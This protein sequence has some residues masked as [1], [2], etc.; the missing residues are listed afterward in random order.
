[1]ALKILEAFVSRD[2]YASFGP[3]QFHPK[4]FALA[5]SGHQTAY[6]ASYCS[7][8]WPTPAALGLPQ[9]PLCNWCQWTLW[10]LLQHSWQELLFGDM[11][12]RGSLH[13]LKVAIALHRS[14]GDMHAHSILKTAQG[15]TSRTGTV[16][17]D[18]MRLA[19]TAFSGQG[20]RV[21]HSPHI[22]QLPKPGQQHCGALLAGD[23]AA[24]WSHGIRALTSCKLRHSMGQEQK[25]LPQLPKSFRQVRHLDLTNISNR[26]GPLAHFGKPLLHLKI[27]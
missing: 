10:H 24:A 22:E 9:L 20:H 12:A 11:T 19:G 23:T 2:V 3:Y 15:H 18:L 16:L 27:L 17:R 7:L 5:I 13:L 8:C 4:L 6:C 25:H 1:M 21:L 14:F 26:V